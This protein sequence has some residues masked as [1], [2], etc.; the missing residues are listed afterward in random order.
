MKSPR[1][2]RLRK[3][4]VPWEAAVAPTLDAAKK[5][6]RKAPR[7]SKTDALKPIPLEP[8]PPSIERPLPCYTPPRHIRKKQGRPT[9]SNM[10]PIETFKRFICVTIIGLVVISTN[11]YAERRRAEDTLDQSSSARTWKPATVGEIYRYI[12]IWLYMGMHPEAT[13]PSFWSQTHRLGQYMSRNRFDQIHRYFSTRDTTTHP[14]QPNECFAWKLEP[15]STILRQNIFRNWSPGTHV[16]IDEA[17]IAFRGRTLHK[18]KMKNKPIDEGYKTW[19]AA[20]SGYTLTWKW[21]SKLEGPEG[22]SPDGIDAPIAPVGTAHLAPTY[23][24]VLTLARLLRDVYSDQSFHFFLDNLFLTVPV[25][26]ALLFL[27]ILC[28][29][30]TRKNAMGV[31]EELIKLK[32]KNQALIWNS[33][34]SK[35]V[36]GVN[37]FLWQDNNAVL[38]IT[39][40]Y[41]LHQVVQ[42]WR[43]RPGDTSTN[44]RIVRPVFGDD[45]RKLLWIPKVIDEYNHHMNGVDHA[46]QLRSNMTVN[47]RLEY[48]IWHPLWHFLIDIAAVNAFICWRWQRPR[49]QRR[50]RAFR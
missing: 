37:C 28:T 10:S 14:R 34:F 20:Q 15:I 33:T 39:T 35:I 13:R 8:L 26:Q 50:H 31:P 18:V 17:M 38:G 11:A 25:A 12:G 48:R 9:F 40:A 43:K 41:C 47:R 22:V 29:G 3:E 42:R 16:A 27:G 2:K 36:N 24:V 4:R 45:V 44:A 21:H 7:T 32:N 5:A 46:N 30:T 23:A 1:P 6:E 19:M 49:G